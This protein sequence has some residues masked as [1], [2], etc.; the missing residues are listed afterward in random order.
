MSNKAQC[1]L[2]LRYLSSLILLYS[3]LML[4][5]S[6]PLAAFD[7][8]LGAVFLFLI[9]SQLLANPFSLRSFGGF[10]REVFSCLLIKSNLPFI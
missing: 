6:A 10:L 4:C 3:P 7:P 5:S 8:L 2:T 1:V 9:L